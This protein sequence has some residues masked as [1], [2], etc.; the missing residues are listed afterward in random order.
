M[1]DVPLELPEKVRRK[2]ESLGETGLCWL[3]NLP[4]QI[5]EIERRWSIKVGRPSR[6]GTEAFVAEAL[7]ADGQQAVLK[8]VMPG[9]DPSHQEMRTLRAAMGR[10]YANLIR[11]DDDENVLLLE[12]LGAQLH[13]LGLAEER[14][15][16]IIC[17]TLRETW[18]PL[19]DGPPFTTGAEKATELAQV[20]ESKWT[21]LGKPCSEHAID[22]AL[23]YAEKRRIAFD[24]AQSVRH[25]ELLGLS[26]R[27]GLQSPVICQ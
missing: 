22:L 14:Q 27:T 4:Q 20:I 21:A 19:P 2:A 5:A 26:M 10:G 17:A 11:A 6:N 24:P 18:M 7:T 23:S 12:R 8:I 25:C 16:E 13:E 15:I 1:R 9:I 3:A